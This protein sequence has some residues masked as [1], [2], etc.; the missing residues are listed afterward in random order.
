MCLHLLKTVSLHK[1]GK[2]VKTNVVDVDLPPAADFLRLIGGPVTKV[3]ILAVKMCVF[4]FILH[5]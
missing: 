4:Y 2:F 1:N 3:S 5:S